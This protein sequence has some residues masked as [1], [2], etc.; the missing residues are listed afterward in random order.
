MG[1]AT[2]GSER[3]LERLRGEVEALALPA[4]RRVGT[5]G[6]D[7]ARA[8]L[9]GR[10]AELG[11]EP[12]G[13]AFALPYEAEGYPFA[14]L[15]GVAPGA[16]R[17][18]APVLI[19]AHYDTA[20]DWAGADDNAAAV[21]IALETARRLVAVPAA[22]DV[23]VALFDAEEPPF[24]HTYAMGSTWFY[25]RQ[26]TGPVHAAL[27]MDL[28]GHALPM[29]GLEDL[30]FVTG[31]ESDPELERAILDLLDSDRLAGGAR[32]VTALNRY[33]GDMSDHHVFRLNE[34]P[35]LFLT[36]GRWPHYHRA[37]D[38]PERL[39]YP[40]M[41]A[42][43]NVLEALTRDVAG[44]RLAGPW[45]GYDTTATD[46][47]TMRAALGGMA[48]SLGVTLESR[49]DIERLAGLLVPEMGL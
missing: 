20:G 35:Y 13:D 17:A 31:M 30:V 21:S 7:V 48:A 33:V 34:V 1:P 46:L 8:H 29:A 19:A 27:V 14:N 9:E 12:Y 36:G 39:D 24:F 23:V 22:R 49:D 43:A 25:E 26:A 28:V 40:K 6:H 15:I 44:R 41:A 10:L 16:D 2:D 5:P 42:V 11:L 18:Q 32:I 47:R 3:T 37:S 45:E 38:T 4:G